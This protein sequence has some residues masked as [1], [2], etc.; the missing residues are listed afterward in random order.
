MGGILRGAGRRGA[1]R[2]GVARPG[3]PRPRRAKGQVFRTYPHCQRC[4]AGT[5]AAAGEGGG[6]ASGSRA[7]QAWQHAEAIT[8]RTSPRARL[9][10]HSSRRP[11]PRYAAHRTPTFG[12][13]CAL[14]P[15]PTPLRP[16]LCMCAACR[17]ARRLR[18]RAPIAAPGCQQSNLAGRPSV[19]D[20]VD[21]GG[22]SDCGQA[23]RLAPLADPRH[24]PKP[25]P[26]AHH[27]PPPSGDAK[28]AAMASM[29]CPST[30]CSL[31]RKPG[32]NQCAGRPHPPPG[33]ARMH[34]C[35][36]NLQRLFQGLACT[37]I[38]R[39]LSNDAPESLC[40]TFWTR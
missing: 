37:C 19:T 18:G 5:A 29:P 4:N 35:A 32:A 25:R 16:L 22:R 24:A 21:R 1:S 15:T 36:S 3:L 17:Q 34:T 33:A 10:R 27:G 6:P 20:P 12:R 9:R 40:K 13:S 39:K 23:A 31:S 2:F 30:S 7:S 38:L 28:A 14:R 26:G 11:P 8:R